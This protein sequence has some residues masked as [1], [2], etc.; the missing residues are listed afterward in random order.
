[1]TGAQ[2]PGV[3]SHL[4][5]ILGGGKSCIGFKFSQ[6]EMKVVPTTLLESFKFTPTQEIAWTIGLSTPKVKD[7]EDAAYRLPL[8]VEL[9]GEQDGQCSWWFSTAHRWF[10]KAPANFFRHYLEQRLES[11][12]PRPPAFGSD[13]DI[14][15]LQP[16]VRPSRRHCPPTPPRF[17]LRIQSEFRSGDVAI[18]GNDAI[19]IQDSLEK[20]RTIL[21][22]RTN[23]VR[24][25]DVLLDLETR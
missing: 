14:R 13:W 23:A 12:H 7:S 19:G 2:I 5:T 18:G 24:G 10:N 16:H 4:M 1:M 8:R 6:L 17:N 20:Q 25:I 21:S 3:Y 9:I 15:P 11:C 22:T